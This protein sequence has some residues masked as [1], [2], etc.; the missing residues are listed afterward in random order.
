MSL[1]FSVVSLVKM[2]I[3]TPLSAPKLH[4]SSLSLLAL[5][6]RRTL[7]LQSLYRGGESRSTGVICYL[8]N[9]YRH[10]RNTRRIRRTVWTLRMWMTIIRGFPLLRDTRACILAIS[11]TLR[12]FVKRLTTIPLSSIRVS[13]GSIGSWN[14]ANLLGGK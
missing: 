13:K 12:L 9:T 5:R 7:S 1:V 3:L 11:M 8:Q 6:L 14:N 10:P 4:C 2:K